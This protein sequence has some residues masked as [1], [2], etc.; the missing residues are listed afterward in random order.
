[1]QTDGQRPASDQVYGAIPPPAASRERYGAPALR[2]RE[3]RRLHAYAAGRRRRRRRAS[4]GSAPPSPRDPRRE[5]VD[6]VGLEPVGMAARVDVPVDHGHARVA[7]RSRDD[8]VVHVDVRMVGRPQRQP[9]ACASPPRHPTQRARPRSRSRSGP[10]S[11]CIRPRS[12]LSGRPRA[13][14]AARRHVR[15]RRLRRAAVARR[16][17]GTAATSRSRSMP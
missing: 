14:A 6:T 7:R 17:A 4:C 1:M 15:R 5:Q 8:L 12:R 11:R 13:R 10:R 9:E 2:R 16:P 3:H